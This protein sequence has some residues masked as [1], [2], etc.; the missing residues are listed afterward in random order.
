VEVAGGGLGT[1]SERSSKQTWTGVLR[2]DAFNSI[3]TDE[4]SHRCV[5]TLVWNCT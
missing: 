1:T 2:L 3:F 5:L 4:T